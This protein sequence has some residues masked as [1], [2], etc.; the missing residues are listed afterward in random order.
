MLF[1]Y[2]GHVTAKQ[3]NIPPALNATGPARNTMEVKHRSLLQ[4]ISSQ[5]SY[6]VL[7]FLTYGILPHYSMSEQ[8]LLYDAVIRPNTVGPGSETGGRGRCALPSTDHSMRTWQLLCAFCRARF[9]LSLLFYTC[10]CAKGLFEFCT[11][12][13][14]WFDNSPS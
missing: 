2:V 14:F 3:W 7:N 1:T 13:K 9:P 10:T 11:G 8:I 12:P 5:L 6:L 4:Q